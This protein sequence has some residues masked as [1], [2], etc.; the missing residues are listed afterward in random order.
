MGSWVGAEAGWVLT[1]A[2]HGASLSS[3][4]LG[5][6]GDWGQVPSPLPGGTTS[7]LSRGP[8][9]CLGMGALRPLS[10]WGLFWF[11][12]EREGGRTRGTRRAR[13]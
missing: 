4:P 8:H 3:L 11:E 9:P 6:W 13:G 5:L 12:L 7:G 2:G 1:L 10:F